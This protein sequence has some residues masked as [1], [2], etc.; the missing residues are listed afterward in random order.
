[1]QDGSELS[2]LRD[3]ISDNTTS[4]LMNT[5]RKADFQD[6]G[7]GVEDKLSSIS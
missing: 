3:Q 2:N 1:M 4:H 5:K 6:T 7:R